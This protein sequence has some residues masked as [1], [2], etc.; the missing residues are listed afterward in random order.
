M[1]IADVSEYVKEGTALENEAYKRGWACI[2][3]TELFLCCRQVFQTASAVL[4][5]KWTDLT[6]SV[7]MEI[8]GDGNVVS[9]KLC[10]SVICSKERMT[11]NNVNK[12]LE[13]GDEEL[14]RDTSIFCRH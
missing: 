8:T 3:Q 4:I 2:W 5:R 1:H 11:Y 9:H 7:F 12:M 10:K 6:L 13:D 14:V